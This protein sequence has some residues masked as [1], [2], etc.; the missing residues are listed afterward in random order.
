MLAQRKKFT[1]K[2]DDKG[3]VE[4]EPIGIQLDA[5]EAA[6]VAEPEPV[7]FFAPVE[8]S[9]DEVEKIQAWALAEAKKEQKQR[10]IDAMKSVA[11]EEAR[12]KMGLVKTSYS[13]AEQARLK[14]LV[15]WTVDL[16]EGGSRDGDFIWMDAGTPNGMILR[17]GM[18]VTTTRAVYDSARDM[19]NK[20]WVQLAIFKGERSN[21]YNRMRGRFE[22]AYGGGYARGT[23]GAALATPHAG[24]P[25]HV[26]RELQ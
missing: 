9:D 23:G 18:T 13:D 12:R 1:A 21:H 26:E 15:S 20:Q 24:V 25:D 10:K 2:L 5:T 22:S 16:P 19:M 3:E 8:L 7:D 6:P 17:N 4:M 11:L 14:E